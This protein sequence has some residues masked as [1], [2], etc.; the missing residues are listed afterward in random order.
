MSQG[1]IDGH[2]SIQGVTDVGVD[3]HRLSMMLIANLERRRRFLQLQQEYHAAPY[4]LNTTRTAILLLMFLVVGV[5][6]GYFGAAILWSSMGKSC[7]RVGETN[8]NRFA[9][10]SPNLRLELCSYDGRVA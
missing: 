6:R 10:P 1:A 8:R 9:R 7:F 2:H 3:M 4:F 5:F